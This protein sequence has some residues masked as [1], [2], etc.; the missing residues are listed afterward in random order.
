MTATSISASTP[1]PQPALSEAQRILNTFFAPSKT[2]ADLKRKPSWWVPWLLISI[3]SLLFMYAVT[4]KIGGEQL[5]QNYLRNHPKMAERLE[6][7]PPEQQER[8]MRMMAT[9]FKYFGY[10][11]PVFTLVL[12]LIIAGVIMATMNFGAGAEIPFRTSMAVV[13]YSWLPFLVHGLLALVILFAGVAPD[14]F[15]L[16]NPVAT[17]LGFL[18]ADPASSPGLYRLAASID[19][20]SIWVVILMGL[21]F[22]TVSKLTRSTA[23]IIVAAWWLLVVLV[24]AG[25]A[26]AFS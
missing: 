26:A 5:A 19:I 14:A 18:I 12:W 7:A 16:E 11:V 21:G 13:A 22:A 4:Q 23:T 20:F 6:K 3:V 9:S 1:A 10:A 25:W 2:F 17:N 15:N 24:R 8:Q